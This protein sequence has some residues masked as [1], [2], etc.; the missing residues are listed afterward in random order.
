MSCKVS[1]T[2]FLQS[3]NHIDLHQKQNSKVQRAG[4]ASMTIKEDIVEKS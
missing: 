1:V 4:Q 3:A 2:F